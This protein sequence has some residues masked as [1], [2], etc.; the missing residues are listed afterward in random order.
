MSNRRILNLLI[1]V[2]CI[3]SLYAQ[4]RDSDDAV[5]IAKQHW[6]HITRNMKM[7]NMGQYSTTLQVM[8]D[9]YVVKRIDADST[10]LPGYVIVSVDESMP[11]ILA[12]SDNEQFNAYNLPQHIRSWMDGYKEMQA[13]CISSQED[14]KSWLTASYNENGDVSPILNNTMWGQDNPYNLSCP[15]IDGK[16]CPTGCVATALAQIMKFYHWPVS[17]DGLTHYFTSTKKLEI[18]YDFQ[19]LNIDWDN[20]YNIYGPI[21][22]DANA[23]ESINDIM[24]LVAHSLTFDEQY[25]ITQC[26]LSLNNAS[27]SLM[28]P[29]RGDVALLLFDHND[30]FLQ[31]V[32]TTTYIEQ[33]DVRES[34]SLIDF[35]VSIPNSIEDGEYKIRVGFKPEGTNTWIPFRSRPLYGYSEKYCSIDVVKS[36]NFIIIGNKKFKCS[37]TLEQS[38]DIAELLYAT[39]A[40]VNMDYDVSSSGTTNEEAVKGLKQYLRYDKDMFLA[41]P[42]LFSDKQWH[43][44]LQKELL[45]NRPVYYSGR[46][47]LSGHAFVIDGMRTDE[48]GITYYHVN[49][50]WD[51]LCNGYYLLN[52]LRPKL[53][54]TGGLADNNYSNNTS[55]IIGMMPEDNVDHTQIIC[56]DINI[57]TTDFFPGQIVSA[58]LDKITLLSSV[59]LNGNLSVELH[60]LNSE[61]SN[62]IQIYNENNR[63]I[64]VKRGVTNYYLR[65]SIPDDAIA[66]QY[67][68]KIA[69]KLPDETAIP[70]IFNN[71]PVITIKNINEWHGGPQLISKQSIAARGVRFDRLNSSSNKFCLQIDSLINLSGEDV[72]G[73][74]SLLV[75]DEEGKLVTSLNEETVHLYKNEVR[76]NV[77]ISCSFSKYLFD[78][79]YKISI[80]YKPSG[81]FSWTYCN[82]MFFETT[83]WWSSFEPFYIKMTKRQDHCFIEGT[84]FDCTD[85]PISNIN[86][87]KKTDNLKEEIYDISGRKSQENNSKRIII[88]NRIKTYN[89]KYFI[90]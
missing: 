8:P 53:A 48:N 25:S 68:M 34:Y 22:I 38:K 65:A 41:T 81:V 85:I 50:G 9:Y 30:F 36:N 26:R 58:R 32:S 33:T 55:M 40:A 43:N 82:L 20:I 84:V 35:I 42:D 19:S 83:M 67:E 27:F 61:E 57:K 29:F 17:G 87:I 18:D 79:D 74:L 21:T 14:I 86:S 45:K 23:D 59:D 12:Y 2:L 54:G 24:G 56:G 3:Q 66:G 49:W 52:Q 69:Y 90:R 10:S 15:E 63:T 39:G 73:Q 11:P 75:C 46:S 6:K 80:G 13:V 71:C 89:E 88:K 44:I 37:T 77:N 7:H 78:G 62:I 51:G 5:S 28:L 1:L 72:T 31:Q 47:N 16:K 76:R 4:H 64:N 70:I 60:P